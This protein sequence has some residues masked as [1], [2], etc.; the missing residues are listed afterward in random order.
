MKLH[1][2]PLF[3]LI[4]LALPSFSQNHPPNR[5]FR[6]VW[7]AT[8]ANIDWP[9]QKGLASGVQQDEYRFILKEQK[10]NGMNAVVVQVRPLPM[11]FT[12]RAVNPGQCGSRASRAPSRTHRTIHSNSW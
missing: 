4:L 6:A 11:R 12:K 8:V 5:E 3:L 1:K 9:S 2:L 7:I 10:K